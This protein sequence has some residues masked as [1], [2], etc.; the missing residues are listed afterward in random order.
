MIQRDGLALRKLWRRSGMPEKDP[1]TGVYTSDGAVWYGNCGELGGDP[2]WLPWGEILFM[3]AMSGW[4]RMRWMLTTGSV[5][6]CHTV[7]P[8][9]DQIFGTIQHVRAPTAGRT[10]TLAHVIQ[11]VPD[12]IGGINP[13]TD[14]DG[15]A[16]WVDGTTPPG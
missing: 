10:P 14:A 1:T 16:D 5:R 11:S 13:G 9:H 4:D 2:H 6:R 12:A 3:A 7:R 15:G 8:N